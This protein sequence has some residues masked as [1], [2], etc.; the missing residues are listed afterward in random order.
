[1]VKGFRTILPGLPDNAETIRDKLSAALDLIERIDVHALHQ[2]NLR[3]RGILVADLA[4]EDAK[5]LARSHTC[6][7]DADHVSEKPAWRVA[8][9]LVHQLTHARLIA[10]GIPYNTRFKARVE[11]VC[12]DREIEFA[13]RAGVS[14][15]KFHTAVVELEESFF[16]SRR[17]RNRQ[18]AAMI[19]N[20]LPR[21][22]ARRPWLAYE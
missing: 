8:M 15:L 10:L 3:F 20:G 1:M 18:Q 4:G 9:S 22:L 6:L 12:V 13:A 2:A 7:L 14:E 17:R 21:F 19:R 11:S 16:S 5:Y